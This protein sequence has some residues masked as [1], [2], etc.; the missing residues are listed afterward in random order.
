MA[1]RDP[2][3]LQTPSPFEI[4]RR[5][6]SRVTEAVLAQ[7][8]F[9]HDA[10]NA[11]L[12]AHLAGTD[13][14]HGALFGDPAIEGAAGYVS[15]GIKPTDLS[16]KLLHP[17]LI[18]AL[19]RGDPGEDYRFDYPAYQ[20]QLDA[21]RLL[22]ASERKSVLVSSGTGSGKTECF[23]VPLLNDLAREVEQSGPLTGVR[24]LMLYP[25]NA[26]IAS[27][28][29]RLRRWTQPFGS[30]IRFA[31][32]NGQM[33]D[34]RKHARDQAEED[35][36]EQVLYRTTL[37]QNPPPI[38][39][40]NNTMLEYL[41]I[42]REDQPIVDASMGKLRW[43]IIDEAH[44]YVGSAAAEVSLLLRRVL[45]K[46]GVTAKDIRFVAT[47]ATIGGTGEDARVDL[48][49]YL[50]DLAGVPLD[51][52]HVVFGGRDKV[53]LPSPTTPLPLAPMLGDAVMLSRQPL[54][55]E[56][57]RAAEDHGVALA[58]IAARCLGSD[59]S[60]SAL[61]E[62]IAGRNSDSPLL[63]LRIHNF[64]RAIPGLWSCLN[65]E[66]GRDRPQGW[67][68]GGIYF[69]Q[70]STCS[71]CKAPVFEI[72]GCRECG[73]PWLNA[74]DHGDR[75]LAG[76]LAVEDDEFRQASDREDEGDT[77]SEEEDQAEAPS[78]VV[79]GTRRL[80]A[81]RQLGTISKHCVDLATGML[82]ER[83]SEGASIGMSSPLF[84]AECPHCHA[85]P[86]DNQASP[87]R[88]FRFG[89]PFLIQNAAPTV[90]EGVSPA[91]TR[92][93]AM[94]AD[95]RQL[96][97]FTDSRQG[98]ARFAA[99]IETMSERGAVRALIYHM[100]QR[101]A[102][103]AMIDDSER[104]QLEE[105]VAALSALVEKQPILQTALD[106]TRRKLAGIN[107][108]APIPWNEAVKALAREPLV[109][110]WIRSVWDLDRDERYHSN[111]ESLANFLLL[112]E[113][114]RRPRRANALET[115][116]FAQ[117]RFD[118]IDRL[119]EASVPEVLKRKGFN[120][121][122]WRAYLY[123][124]LDSPLRAYFVLQIDRDD[125]R[126]LLPK[127]A[128]LRNI[129]G[130][131]ETK[132][133][134]SDLR[135]PHARA[136]G[137][138]ANAVLALERALGLDSA[139]PSERA[140]INEVLEKAWHA[141]RPLL[142]GSGSTYAL[143]IREGGIASVRDAWICPITHRVLPRLLFGRSQYGVDGRAMS[144]AA[145]PQPIVMPR[146][147]VTMPRNDLERQKLTEFVETDP[148]IAALRSRGVWGDLHD[149]AASFAP[150]IRV[151][152]HSAQQPPHRLR[153]FEREFKAHQ[154][155]MLT[156]STTMEMGVDIGSVE[157][158]LN[159]NVPPSIANYRQRVGRA[160]RRGQSF[161]SS[162]TLARDTPLDRETFQN[163]VRYL[164]RELRA[165]KVTLDSARIVQRH[166]NALLLATWL[167]EA[168]GQLTRI[169]VGAFYGFPQKL[170]L[171][172]EVNA[173]AAQ[174]ASWLRDPSTTAAQEATIGRLVSGTALALDTTILETAAD[175]FERAQN[176][177][178]T[179]WHRMREQLLD[180]APEARA[181]IEIRTRRMTGEP[182]L[183]E[184][185]NASLLPG[186]GFPTSVLM[187][188][189]SCRETA[190]RMRSRSANE[191]DREVG[192]NQ[193]YEYPSRTSDIAIREYAPGAEVVIDGLVWT[194]AGVTLNWRRPASDANA[195]EI[196]SIRTLWTC[197]DCHDSG[198][199]RVAETSCPACGSAAIENAEFLEPAGFRV[200]WRAKPHAET[201]QVH[202]IEPIAPR[203]SARGADWEP[204]PNPALGRLRAAGDGLV[205]HAS[206]G[207][208]KL[209]YQ[210]CLDC[211]RAAE[212]GTN[213]LQDHEPLTPL[214]GHQGRCTGNDKTYAITAPIMLAY[215]ELTDVAEIQFYGLANSGAAW[216]MASALREALARRLGIEPRELGLG[217][218]N[219]GASLGQDGISIFLF[220][221]TAGGAGYAPRLRDDIGGLLKEARRILDC[222]AKCERACSAC[223]L[224][225]DLH[226]QQK[227]IDRV[228]ALALTEQLLIG[229][230]GPEQDDVAYPGA[231][232]APPAADAL[233]RSLRPESVAYIYL[234]E[235]GDLTALIG[236][237]FAGLLAT[238]RRVGAK[239]RIVTPT[240]SLDGLDEAFR[241]GLRN[242]SHRLGFTL[243]TGN[244]TIA[245]NGASLIAGID[246]ST[247]T[248]F[249]TR[250]KAS[251][252]AGIDWGKG[253][254]HPVVSTP[255]DRLPEISPVPEDALE[256]PLQSGDRVKILKGDPGRPLRLFGSGFVS[257]LVEDELRAAG[258]WR[259]GDLIGL[260]YSDRYLKAPLP[261]ALMIQAMAALRDALNGK[262]T[263]LPL[264]IKTEPLQSDRNRR[265]PVRLN[266]NWED[267]IDR[268]TIIRGL[269][270]ALDLTSIYDGSNAG[271]GR[272]V[273]LHYG[274]G[275][276]AI[277]LLDQGFGYWRAQ[278]GDRH[279]FRA[280]PQQQIKAL[281]TSGA[282]VSGQGET[283]IA[284]ARAQ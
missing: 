118:R 281:L 167:R 213:G 87:L 141:I 275:E 1:D 198:C 162:L 71:D 18:N 21:W 35:V 69:E 218:E 63:P 269:A 233:A 282:F 248:G 215:E 208:A 278:S 25:L 131:K 28:Q 78:V 48:Q 132:G 138:K 40:T 164:G 34:K 81:T 36:P 267:D 57:I 29:E 3:L 264:A 95:G 8:G 120:I 175:M 60:A 220:D 216:A 222:S 186:H 32:Y 51:Q 202:Y 38:L 241:R 214:K 255:I 86:N 279:D 197:R 193:R 276:Q 257:R 30:H 154:I 133:K 176:A 127:R 111:P 142:E 121:V 76:E 107:T 14:T 23:L 91:P 112:R 58:D 79:T 15:S 266:H 114:A 17:K 122:D 139:D 160:G 181:G 4:D 228:P 137:T 184:L 230:A 247:P 232:L 251:R 159:T 201:D 246:G 172:P 84:T 283:Y 190:D 101:R 20:H 209:G 151:E 65:P 207:E 210:I 211:G 203:I 59:V 277:I 110:R 67:P 156:C 13:P 27:Q 109:D 72:I 217:M 39:V 219:R 113:L 24:A 177:F 244:S 44:S 271:H 125:A 265:P 70:R 96:L 12:R 242:A 19:I 152:E 105:S 93:V 37:R 239:V 53:S 82:P 5:L 183:K 236:P 254:E 238:A 73:E 117:L 163:P 33:L 9:R 272:K 129:V 75:L 268:E 205:F 258:L 161:S 284:V 143:N 206:R 42:R 157:A 50:A 212:P 179:Q 196:Q 102:A 226:A 10:L 165:P 199:T 260:E 16:G 262:G 135:W 108:A 106:D 92:D 185:A 234:S 148:E 182:L 194:S 158:V 259:P 150:Y 55:Q 140:E 249:F 99:S 221:Q 174:F 171:P 103:S 195:R 98:T 240:G 280:S 119:S 115:L 26:L 204:I 89:A 41:T 173:P 155:N 229:L 97:S 243:W 90:L 200:D 7:G 245:P 237:P 94:P 52:V 134:A 45:E 235:L 225:A 223:V 43:I 128:F 227:V 187:F 273:T 80:L 49:R 104:G 74:F 144:A 188:D 250:D 168:D 261:V 61:L 146:L 224:T 180:L 22:T 147:P 68:F 54:V 231:L 170:D 6:R 169:K 116:G 263:T 253:L 2:A 100:V 31:L 166:A 46:F 124:L 189:N 191:Q 77:A 88:S 64:V 130:P 66:C 47:S 270:E 136:V 192:A 178:G 153:E 252:L 85:A 56:I 62:A 145:V 149:R 256:R 123:Y 83:R 274:N 126:W 11:Y